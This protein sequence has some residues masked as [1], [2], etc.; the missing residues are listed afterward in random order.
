MPIVRVTMFE[1]RDE[2]TKDKLARE[3]ADAVAEHTGNSF[4]EIHVIFDEVPRASWS[5]SLTLASRRGPRA[6]RK[7]MRSDYA[8]VSRITYDP[9]TESEYLRIRRDVINPG[10]ATQAGFVSSLLLRPRDKEHEYLL[11]NKWATEEHSRAYTS[12]PVHDRLRDEAL[13]LLPERLQTFA[14]DV[15]HLDDVG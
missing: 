13:R 9:K 5:R 11:I 3:L 14:A 12:G 1:G 6:A 8:S 4:D 15:V 7:P 2:E 10:M